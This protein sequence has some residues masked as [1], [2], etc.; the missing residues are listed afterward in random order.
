MKN[1]RPLV[2]CE[3]LLLG[4]DRITGVERYT[5]D[6]LCRSQGPYH[7]IIGSESPTSKMVREIALQREWPVAQLTGNSLVAQQIG[8]GWYLRT[9]RSR[10]HGVHHFSLSPGILGGGRPFT[11]T[12]HDVSAWRFPHTMSRGMRYLYRPLIERALRSSQL[13]GIITVSR[14]SQDEIGAVLNVPTQ[15]IAVVYPTLGYLARTHPRAVPKVSEPFYLHVGTVEPRKNIEL[16]ISAFRRAGLADSVLYLV[17][18][19]GWQSLPALPPNVI[20]LPHV[21]DAELAWLYQHAVALI[22]A[23]DYEGAG[24]PPAEALTAGCRVFLRDI[25][26]YRE[27]YGSQANCWMF[28]ASDELSDLI[29]FPPAANPGLFQFPRA[30]SFDEAVEDLHG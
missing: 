15:R 28:K 25:P 8:L 23:S 14:F 5:A 1:D 20:H 22:S 18:R 30:K 13:R 7:L 19:Q 26:V 4:R 27:I 11:L 29:R 12:I 3:A 9:Q 24:L 10:L 6:I 17:G 2:A 16:L 21:R